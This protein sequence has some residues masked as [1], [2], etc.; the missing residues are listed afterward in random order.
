M[1]ILTISNENI[2]YKTEGTRL[3]AIV[4]LSKGP[5]YALLNNSSKS[6]I[7][8]SQFSIP[9]RIEKNL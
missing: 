9:L 7:Q 8:E 6:N 3:G 4:A 1:S 5:E 2:F